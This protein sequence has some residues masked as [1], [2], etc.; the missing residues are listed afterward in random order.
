MKKILSFIIAI[1]PLGAVLSCTD[2]TEVNNK[3][4]SLD[5]RVSALEK[6]VNSLNSN[7]LA[8]TTLAQN[9]TI[10]NVEQEGDTYKITLANGQKIE[11]FQGTIGIG[12]TPVLSIDGDGYW[13]VDYGTGPEPVL[14]KG[15]PVYAL[16]VD[17]VTPTFAV[18]ADNYWIVSYD[19]G[20]NWQ[21]VLYS[22]GEK[23]GQKVKAYNE[24]GSD[25][26][27]HNVEYDEANSVFIL[28]LKNGQ[29]YTVPVVND[30]MC[31][32]LDA[33][34]VQMFDYEETRTYTVEMNGVAD[35][36]IIAPFGW[37]AILQGDD[38][39]I[40]KITAPAA[41]TKA[42]IADSDADVAI[43]AFTKSGLSTSARLEVALTG[44]ELDR[45]PFTSPSKLE[46]GTSEAKVRVLVENATDWYYLLSTSAV[47][48]HASEIIADGV[49]G[50]DNIF[51]LTGLKQAYTYYLYTTAEKEGVLAPVA[52]CNFKT[53]I[54]NDRYQ[55]FLDGE[56]II[57]CGEH[58]NINNMPSYKLLT[59]TKD[60]DN[61]LKDAMQNGGV[62]F[63]ETPEG[64]S[65]DPAPSVDVKNDNETVIVGRYA[66]T[67]AKVKI[68]TGRLCI[69]A[70]LAMQYVEFDGTGRKGNEFMV[71][72]TVKYVRFDS[73]RFLHTNGYGLLIADNNGRWGSIR[74]MNN[75]FKFVG[76]NAGSVHFISTGSWNNIALTEEL[77]V[78]NNIFYFPSDTRM[79]IFFPGANFDKANPP[80]TIYR[81]KVS[82]C[83][84]T[85]YGGASDWSMIRLYVADE[86]KL[87]K[88]IYWFY[89]N[90]VI[91]QADMVDLFGDDGIAPDVVFD[92]NI[93]Y[94]GDIRGLAGNVNTAYLPNP[95][96]VSK[97]ASDPLAGCDPANF[98]FTPIPAYKK[99]GAQR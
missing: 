73:C 2:L 84:N 32:I 29:A 27:F 6:A 44:K 5:S 16:G 57:I 92:S 56:D 77:T 60:G 81:T 1:I 99:Y 68:A 7:V 71:K 97:L 52:Q 13:K 42:T 70:G 85:F 50:T 83:S 11:I 65:F 94:R 20:E 86:V 36:T 79:H 66:D 74:L 12:N 47:A 93:S 53:G 24:G 87:Q 9:Q 37:S 33:E 69:K 89:P 46:V 35:Y 95:N 76:P 63:L 88:N 10:N 17:G 67:F 78:D 49:K 61:A 48:P 34:E 39:K 28:T 19:G 45:R 90:S 41:L 21:N 72:E 18:D 8:L 62:I 31:R 4:D 64:T 55:A 54:T 38:L 15:K 40:L 3:L 58:Y 43:I 14:Q 96:T 26:Y 25:S 80:Q 22:T 75:D 91:S 30:F 23:A 98:D 51:T 82:V 59:A